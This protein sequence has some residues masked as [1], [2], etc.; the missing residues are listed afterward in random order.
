[1]T[2]KFTILT[3]GSRQ[4]HLQKSPER[5]LLLHLRPELQR[6]GIGRWGFTMTG[7]NSKENEAI[8]MS[9]RLTSD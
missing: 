8:Q 1:M 9:M 3:C 2:S 7:E 4:A 6:H 5:S